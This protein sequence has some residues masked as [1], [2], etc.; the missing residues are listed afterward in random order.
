MRNSHSNG[1]RGADST[2]SAIVRSPDG[3]PKLAGGR[4]IITLCSSWSVVNESL[5]K[6][7]ARGPWL[8]PMQHRAN[9]APKTGPGE[10]GGT[11][12]ARRTSWQ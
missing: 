2:A 3:P 8:V 7:G 9:R 4:R 11:Y 1:A 5:F 12:A 10:P 6:G